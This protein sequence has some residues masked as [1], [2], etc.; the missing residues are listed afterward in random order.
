[1]IR[2]NRYTYTPVCDGCGKELDTEQL[3][4]LAVGAMKAEGWLFVSGSRML[5]QWYHFCPVCKARR[6]V[7]DR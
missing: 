4:D 2:K 7:N 6:K 5:A 3:Y 1:M